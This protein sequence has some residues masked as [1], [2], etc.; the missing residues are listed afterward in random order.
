MPIKRRTVRKPVR[1]T[2][3][4][5]VR[6]RVI[7]RPLRASGVV[8]LLSALVH[9]PR[10]SK[11]VKHRPMYG[12]FDKNGAKETT[13]EI[14]RRIYGLPIHKI[15]DEDILEKIYRF[16]DAQKP[17]ILSKIGSGFRS[18]GGAIY[19]NLVTKPLN[20]VRDNKW[21]SRGLNGIGASTLGKVASFFGWGRN[22]RRTTRTRRIRRM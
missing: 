10:A 4:R 18:L 20:Y 17:G 16:H 9:K 11:R 2:V 6:K 1:R 5:T 19:N 14:A 3:R 12:G 21:I 15:Y 22:R 8:K 7:R 13:D